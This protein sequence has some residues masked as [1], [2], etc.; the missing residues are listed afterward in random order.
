MEEI[1]EETEKASH[2]GKMWKL[3]TNIRKLPEKYGKPETPV[4]VKEGR[5]ITEEEGQRK[6]WMEYF[7]ELF[8][9]PTPQ[10]PPY[11]PPADSDLPINC[12]SATKEKVRSATK[13]LK[14]NVNE[15]TRPDGIPAEAL[16]ADIDTRVRV[17]HSLLRKIRRLERRISLWHGS[18]LQWI[19]LNFMAL[20]LVFIRPELH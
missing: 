13:Q 2:Q 14:N 18:I 8:N 12:N 4:K 11:I 9:R 20:C 10:N 3:Y 6:R 19:W 15:A 16:K 7:K 5:E 17:L 1:A